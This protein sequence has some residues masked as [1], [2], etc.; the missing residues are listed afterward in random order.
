MNLGWP[1]ILVEIFLLAAFIAHIAAAVS[2]T[3]RNR[4]ARPIGYQKSTSVGE[5]SQKSL[6]SSTMIW[7]GLVL[8]VFTVLHI[9]TFKYDPGVEEGYVSEIDG[10]RRH[11][12]GG[13]TIIVEPWRAKAFPIVKDLVV[14]RSAFDRIVAAGGYVSVNTGSAPDA[15]SVLISREETGRALDSSACI[16]CGAC[17]AACLNASAALFVGA[18]MSHFSLLPQGRIEGKK[19]VRRMVA[20]MD[21][22]QFGSCSNHGECEAVCPKEISISNITRMRS[23]YVKAT[24]L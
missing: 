3:W 13:D 18:K 19:R 6:A 2:V 23:E 7:T 21:E 16:G 4:K 11:F 17:V 15:N 24:L 8:L 14:D 12:Q 10:Q 5:P 20:R 22:E 9:Y 1:L